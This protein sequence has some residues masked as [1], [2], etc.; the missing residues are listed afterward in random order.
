MDRRAP[1]TPTTGV[2]VGDRVVLCFRAS[3]AGY[4]TVWSHDAEGGVP[5]RI[6]PNEFAA[7]TADERAAPVGAGEETC[8]GDDDGFRLEVSRPLGDASVYLH[9]TQREELQFR[10]DGLP[11]DPGI[12]SAGPPAVRIELLAVPTSSTDQAPKGEGTCAA[13]RGRTLAFGE[14]SG[15]ASRGGPGRSPLQPW[16]R[17]SV[18]MPRVREERPLASSASA[19]T[20][21]R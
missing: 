15:R 16:R 6:Y 3:A 2:Q 20:S 11:A 21:G 8:I 10:R 7:E 14:G 12:P 18:R 5:A 9:F 1:C 4:V 19:R 13:G 17:W